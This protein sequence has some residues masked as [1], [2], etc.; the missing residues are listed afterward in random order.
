MR[1]AWVLVAAMAACTPEEGAPPVD[2]IAPAE[3]T[4]ALLREIGFEPVDAGTSRGF[5]LD[6][7]VTAAGARSGCG[8]ADVTAPDGTPG[9]DNAFG[10][11]LP[12]IASLGGEALQSLV[13]NAVLSGELLLLVEM[14]DLEATPV[15]EC[16]TGRIVRGA[17]QPFLGTDGAILPGQTFDVNAEFP[18]AELSCVRPQADGSIL[19]DGVQL[20]LPLQVFDEHIDLTMVEGRILLQPAES[21][22]TGVIGG[23]IEVEELATNVYGFDAIPMELEDGVVEAVRLTADLSPDAEGVCARVSVTLGYGAVPAFLFED[24]R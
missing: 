20:R 9:I 7:E 3:P 14:D 13:Q 8:R 18:S 12:L 5:D 15:G 2:A 16:T 6:G 1:T 10:A 4:I 23:G 22:W 19:A 24:A 21:G 11:L 17:G